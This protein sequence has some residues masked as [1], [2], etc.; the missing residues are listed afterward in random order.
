MLSTQELIQGAIVPTLCFKNKS[1]RNYLTMIRYRFGDSRG[2]T[3]RWDDDGYTSRALFRSK[4]A[5]GL[6]I[7]GSGEQKAS[8]LNISI[9]N[10]QRWDRNS[11][12]TLKTIGILT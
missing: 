12:D 7:F 1:G 4:P 6:Q 5:S 10:G 2:R 11:K 8:F 3:I 9:G